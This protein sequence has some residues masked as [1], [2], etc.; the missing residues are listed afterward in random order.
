MLSRLG[1][2]LLFVVQ[3]INLAGS[4]TANGED[5]ERNYESPKLKKAVIFNKKILSYGKS[6]NTVSWYLSKFDGSSYSKIGTALNFSEYLKSKKETNNAGIIP[7]WA[8]PPLV[9][10]HVKK[11]LFWYVYDYNMN[12]GVG[13][14]APP[15][16]G[17]VNLN[18]NDNVEKMRSGSFYSS[19]KTKNGH[20]PSLRMN[21][22]ELYEKR[23]GIFGTGGS[24]NIVTSKIQFHH[25]PFEHEDHGVE[26]VEIW[27]NQN[28]EIIST[29]FP[30]LDCALNAALPPMLGAPFPANQVDHQTPKVSYDYIP[31]SKNAALLFLLKFNAKNSKKSNSNEVMNNLSIWKFQIERKKKYLLYERFFAHFSG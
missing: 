11:N 26:H 9:S 5:N 28:G 13:G 18:S 6:G 4:D 31:L 17:W 7:E 1:Y 8:C 20:H 30:P 29:L 10:W 14:V 2:I 23:G 24:Q 27:N 12:R 16:F 22:S 21:Y 19:G 15:S 25:D 3:I